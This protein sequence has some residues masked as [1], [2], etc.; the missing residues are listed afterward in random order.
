M[1]DKQRRFCELYAAKP[2][3]KEAAIG[4]GF[5]AKRAKEQSYRLMKR[6][7]VQERLAE[8][9][10]EATE[11]SM[12]TAIMAL[13]AIRRP[14]AA[15]PRQLWRPDGSL[16]AMHELTAEEA[17]LIQ[18][19]D[20]VQGNLSPGDGQRDKLARIRLVDRSTYVTLAA[21]HFKLIQ[22]AEQNV[23]LHI[24]LVANRLASARRRIAAKPIDI[25]ASDPKT[26][27]N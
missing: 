2:N 16:K 6:R 9:Q 3:A 19:F 11:R 20:V 26:L 27:P 18:S 1:T 7:D 17:S 4:A 22:P 25:L 10:K 5:P 13:E 23:N 21:K 12:L 14:L 8:L 24:D 15:D